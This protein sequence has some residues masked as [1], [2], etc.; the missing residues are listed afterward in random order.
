MR[1]FNISTPV[2]A[3]GLAMEF[4]VEAGGFRRHLIWPVGDGSMSHVF[5]TL[6]ENIIVDA[7]ATNQ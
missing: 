5:D 6:N 4:E 7:S 2:G 3:T 1:G